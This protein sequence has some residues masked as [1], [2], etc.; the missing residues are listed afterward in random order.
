MN[1][2]FPFPLVIDST[3]LTAFSECERRFSWEYLMHYKSKLPSIHLHAGGAYAAGLEEYR[4]SYYQDELSAQRALAMG[5]AKI[6]EAWGDFDP[7]PPGKHNKS[8]DRVLGALDYYHETWP[9]DKDTL[10]PYYIGSD[11]AVE[12]SFAIPLDNIRSPDTGEPIIIAG[13][14]DQ[15]VRYTDAIG[16]VSVYNL[17]DKTT[18][19]M[20]DKWAEQWATRGQFL[21]Y[22][23]AMRNRGIPVQGMI[24]RGMCF[25]KDRYQARQCVVTHNDYHIDRWETEMFIRIEKMR[26]AWVR[27]DWS[28]AYNN[29]CGSYGGCTYKDICITEDHMPFL[30]G[31]YEKRVWNPLTSDE[32]NLNN[33]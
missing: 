10:D 30:E 9:I 18:K 4:K 28:Y 31:N 11:L 17:D 25:Y 33:E 27:N 24:V 12:V 15:V 19:Q 20:G 22:S 3:M 13:R 16:R 2:D 8:L 26:E 21:L 32:E 14:F 7:D 29:N 23:W 1:S 6:Q 5:K